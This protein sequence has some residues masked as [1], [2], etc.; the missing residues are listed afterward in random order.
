MGRRKGSLNRK[1]LERIANPQE[2]ANVIKRGKGRP[3]G[4][5][6]KTTKENTVSEELK[7][8]F[9][10]AEE[11]LYGDSNPRVNVDRDHTDQSQIETPDEPTDGRKCER[12]GCPMDE[13]EDGDI[14]EECEEEEEW[15][16]DNWD[17]E[18]DEDFED[19]EDWDDYDDDDLDEDEDSDD[20]DPDFDDEDDD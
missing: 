14:C 13:F 19:D 5:K 4:S 8:N 11:E 18:W 1:T 17:D 10:E 15:E 2:I 20:W 3:K 6:N 7:E 9:K 12:C 16:D